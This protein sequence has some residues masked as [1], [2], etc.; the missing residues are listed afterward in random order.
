MYWSYQATIKRGQNALRVVNVIC[1]GNTVFRAEVFGQLIKEDAPYAIDDMYWLAE[2][3]RRR[4]G[5][6][7]YVHEARS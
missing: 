6:V 5:R 1:G 2:I 4:L 3:V 7:A